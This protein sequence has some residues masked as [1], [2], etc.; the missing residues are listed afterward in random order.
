MIFLTEVNCR[1]D[2]LG[3]SS[4]HDVRGIPCRTAWRTGVGRTGVIGE[5]VPHCKSQS[6]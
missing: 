1:F 2:V 3:T 5:L 6:Q 4:V